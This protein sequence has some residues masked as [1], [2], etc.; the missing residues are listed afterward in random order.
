MPT[1]TSCTHFMPIPTPQ[2]RQHWLANLRGMLNSPTCRSDGPGYCYIF[3]TDIEL[4]PN[5]H[6][7]SNSGKLRISVT[8]AHSGTAPAPASAR[9]GFMPTGSPMLASLNKSYN[10]TSNLRGPGSDTSNIA[11]DHQVLPEKAPLANSKMGR[12]SKTS[13]I[14]YGSKGKNM[15]TDELLNFCEA[16]LELH[17]LLGLGLAGNI[18]PIPHKLQGRH[19]GVMAELQPG[20]P[21][22]G[23]PSPQETAAVLFVIVQDTLAHTQDMVKQEVTKV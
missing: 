1:T 18:L 6:L 23:S 11:Q 10:I 17:H 5:Q 9:T 14:H 20:V 4:Q 2:Q 22:I 15:A 12:L 19:Y 7:C 16:S 8:I 21:G 13:H 3:A